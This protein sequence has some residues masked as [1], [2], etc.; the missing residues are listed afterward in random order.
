MLDGQRLAIVL[1][2]A[3]GDVVHALPLVSSL[4]AAAPR[5]AIEWITQPV[6][7]EIA[8]R[9]PGVERV[10]TLDR[11]RGWRAYRELRNA[12]HGRRFDLVLDLQVYAKASFVTALLAMTAPSL[13]RASR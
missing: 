5:L 9:H 12:L 6:P 1:L 2:S 11:A 10:W 8:G 7:A 4:K 3:I 13:P